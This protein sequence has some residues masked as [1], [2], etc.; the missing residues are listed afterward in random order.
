MREFFAQGTPWQR[1]L[2]SLST[3]LMLQEVTEYARVL[4]EGQLSPDGLEYVSS[5]TSRQVKR[6]LGLGVQQRRDA[7]SSVLEDQ[8]APALRK[9]GGLVSPGNVDSFTETAR[10]ATTG[11]MERWAAEVSKHGV[12]DG[13]AELLARLLAS[14]LLDS[15]FSA[16]H[17]HKWLKHHT[18]A[19]R[20]PANDLASVIAAASTMLA[21]PERSYRVLVPHTRIPGTARVQAG[22]R[23]LDYESMERYLAAEQL[24]S[25][26]RRAGVG[27]LWFTVSAREPIAALAAAE[28]ETRRLRAR[29][30]VGDPGERAEHDELA[31]VVNA[32]KPT[33]RS[34]PKEGRIF[35]PTLRD[36][37]GLVPVGSSVSGALDDALELLA[38]VEMSTSWASLASMWSAIEGLLARP[39]DQGV[40]AADRAAD[41]VTCSL[42]RAELTA[43]A[44]SA[45]C[46]ATSVTEAAA[47][48]HA[49]FAGFT[50]DAD[51]A[52]AHRLKAMYDDPA[53]VMGRIRFYYKDA[54][55][56]LYNQRNLLVHGG[57]FDSV[58]LP[59]T[60]RTMPP[61]V[62]AAVDRIIHGL[63]QD[64]PV[65]ALSLA[66]RAANELDFLGKPG[67]RSID[68]L[69]A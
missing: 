35:L 63:A 41:L 33:W 45:H 10:Q 67:A 5:S 28:L 25:W 9:G 32:T 30:V 42:P 6:D 43:L 50:D 23:Y 21:E 48:V 7:L 59:A 17:L 57:R 52:A 40:V 19:D 37:S 49:N 51:R 66:A 55:R 11:Y 4:R 26:P 69:L 47:L 8:K 1:R 12:A 46:P 24:P 39:T 44:Q 61:L 13:Q 53:A 16:E 58:T 68:D 36:H 54:F 64:P 65:P 29:C 27:A 31:L 2:W 18:A 62:G 38:T 34:F 14:Q 60:M 20:R 3:P 22:E 15:G 56:R